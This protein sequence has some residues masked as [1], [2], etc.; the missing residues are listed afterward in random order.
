MRN[1]MKQKNVQNDIKNFLDS[2]Y[3]AVT[4]Q[5][6]EDHFAKMLGRA[7]SVNETTEIMRA[8]TELTN[9]SDLYC[10]NKGKYILIKNLPNY[11]TGVLQ[12][13]M[14]GNGFLI[15]DKKGTKDVYIPKEH[16]RGANDG[17]IAL[18]GDRVLVEIVGNQTVKPEGKI[19]KV[20]ERNNKYIIGTVSPYKGNMEFIPN[21]D[22]YKNIK[23]LID[24]RALNKCVDGEVL[25]ICIRDNPNTKE[26]EGEIKAH[27]GHKD[28]P[29]MDNISLAAEYGVFRDFPDEVMD[30]V[31]KLPTEV[32]DEDRVGR[33]D[34]RDKMIFTI[35][36]KDTKDIDDAISLDKDEYGNY[37]LGVHIAD[38]SYYV[39]SGSPLDLEAFKRGTS[40]YL[41]DSVFPMYPHELSNGICSLNEDVD[42]CAMTCE[43]TI[44]PKGKML[45]YKVYP[46]VIHSNKKMN[47]D[48]VNSIIE[49][50][51]VPE[52]YEP[53]A[54]KLKEMNE[55]HKI[56]RE[57]RMKNGATDF[58]TSETKY[59]FD[60]NHKCIGAKVIN[61]GE[62]EKLIEDFMVLANEA[63]SKAV[64]FGITDSD[65]QYNEDKVNPCIY[66]VHDVP[67]QDKVTD[68]ISLCSRLNCPIKGKF[69]DVTKPSQFKKLIDQINNL[70]DEKKEFLLPLAIRTMAKAKYSTENIGHFGLALQYYSHFTSPIRRY[71]DTTLHRLIRDLLFSK[72]QN[73]NRTH[74]YTINDPKTYWENNLPEIAKQSSDR[75]INADELERTADDMYAAEYMQDHIGEYFDVSVSGFNQKGMFVKDLVNGFE[76]MIKYDNIP[77]GHFEY[78]QDLLCAVDRKNK[79]VYNLGDK[80]HL[81]C[82][83][84]S[85]ELRTVDFGF[86]L[87]KENKQK[88]TDSFS[89][90]DKKSHKSYGKK[91]KY[92]N[93][94]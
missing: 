24:Q 39:P 48:D 62:G 89:Y 91:H 29:N 50:N 63:V 14:S 20:I 12:V 75:E 27:I 70:P 55:L 66:R 73:N 35:D 3:D 41:G 90:Q 33:V 28:D 65:T 1:D 17:K 86:E 76:G 4:Y 44:S 34:L 56:V 36:G 7:V 2:K 37:V 58:D 52:G 53:F 10:T 49:N 47:Y 94:K 30:Q 26:I 16:I 23:L 11:T 82:I 25:A 93:N 61:R 83:G 42:R 87:V 6:I 38:V 59:L 32:S 8:L 78:N 69:S 84:A 22:K 43:M 92:G 9:T 71:P 74:L 85:K 46:S 64:T 80:L 54:D 81:M 77:N 72:D 68:F 18:D 51:I 57:K 31:K 45:S 13:K 5:D 40:N 79:K 88:V 67:I 15:Q 19:I 21:D 60:E